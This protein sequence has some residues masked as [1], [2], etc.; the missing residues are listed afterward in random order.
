MWSGVTL[1]ISLPSI[2]MFC[3]GVVSFMHIKRCK[4]SL[5][6][7]A[8][9]KVR[10]LGSVRGLS[11]GRNGEENTGK[12]REAGMLGLQCSAEYE[13]HACSF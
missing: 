2:F 5:R 8:L 3:P 4:T 9:E 13:I 1:S 10:I 7:G 6:G 11:K 12:L